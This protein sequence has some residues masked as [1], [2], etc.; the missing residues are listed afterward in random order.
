LHPTHQNINTKSPQLPSSDKT[1]FTHQHAQEESHAAISSPEAFQ[2]GLNNTSQK[3]NPQHSFSNIP[4]HSNTGLIQTKLTVNTPGDEYEQEADAVADKIMRMADNNSVETKSTP[5]NII[6]RKCETCGK[7]EPEEENE[8]EENDHEAVQRMIMRKC[9]A[10]EEEEKEKILQRKESGN[11]SPPVSSFVTQTLQSSG[12]PLDKATRS[13]MERR[14]GYDFSTVRIHDNSLAH[15]SAKDIN[16]LAYTHQNNIAFGNGQYQ[17]QTIQGRRLLAHELTHV[18]QQQQLS[19]LPFIQRKDHKTK[20]VAKPKAEP[21]QHDLAMPWKNS[22]QNTI[23]EFIR[24]YAI[25]GPNHLQDAEAYDL[26]GSFINNISNANDLEINYKEGGDD[27]HKDKLDVSGLEQMMNQYAVDTF[28]IHDSYTDSFLDMFGYTWESF[29]AARTKPKGKDEASLEDIMEILDDARSGPNFPSIKERRE[30]IMDGAPMDQKALVERFLND[31]KPITGEDNSDKSLPPYVVTG[32][33]MDKIREL[34][35]P[36]NEEQLKSFLA[37]IKQSNV[38]GSKKMLPAE[39]TLSEL[40]ET[41]LATQQMRSDNAKYGLKNGTAETG[42]KKVANRPVHGKIIAANNPAIEWQSLHFS[43]QVYDKVDAF[44]VPMVHIH[45]NAISKK[46]QESVDDEYTHYIDVR[47]DGL[48][49]DKVFE[50]KPLPAGEYIIHAQVDHNFYYPAVFSEP[51]TV[52]KPGEALNALRADS[53]KTEKFSDVGNFSSYNYSMGIINDISSNDEGDRAY[54]TMDQK[55]SFGIDRQITKLEKEIA[56][57]ESLKKHYGADDKYNKWVD[58]KISRLRDTISTLTT[59][60]QNPINKEIQVQGFYV[61]RTPGVSSGAL[62]LSAWYNH[63]NK[64]EGMAKHFYFGN[65]FDRSDIVDTENL[66]FE[67]I[68]FS[69]EAMLETLFVELSSEYPVGNIEVTFQLYDNDD[70]AT[71]RTVTYRRITDTVWKDIKAVAYSLPVQILTNIVAGILTIFPPTTAIG[72]TLGVVYNGAQVVADIAS[73]VNT[74]RAITAGDIINVALVLVDL[75]PLLG[76]AASEASTGLKLMKITSK[77]G[78][79]AGNVYVLSQSIYD[80]IQSMRDGL[81][82]QMAEVYNNITILQDQHAPADIL[83]PQLDELRRLESDINE[84][85]IKI[86]AETLITQAAVMGITHAA[87]SKFKDALEKMP[88][89]DRLAAGITDESMQALFHQQEGRVVSELLP[90]HSST[91]KLAPHPNLSEHADLVKGTEGI[92]SSGQKNSE[93]KVRYEI[94]DDGVIEKIFIEAGLDA[95]LNLLKQH[96]PTIKLLQ[97]YQNFSGKIRILLRRMY[98]L[99]MG[100]TGKHADLVPLPGS[101]AFE[102]KLEIEKLPII[103]ESKAALLADLPLDDVNGRSKLESDIAFLESE[104]AR[105]NRTLDLLEMET[106]EGFV[107]ATVPKNEAAIAA[108]YP[109]PPPGHYYYEKGGK[110]E[111]ERF[112]NSNERPQ[113]IVMENGKPAVE[114]LPMGAREKVL[115]PP[116]ETKTEKTAADPGE[117][118]TAVPDEQKGP[119]AQKPSLPV[120]SADPNATPDKAVQP[121][122]TAEPV[123]DK[124]KVKPT[125]KPKPEKPL[126]KDQ[127]QARATLKR[128]QDLVETLY[129]R[130]QIFLEE[131]AERRKQENKTAEDIAEIRSLER[132]LYRLDPNWNNDAPKTNKDIGQIKEAE[133]ALGFAEVDAAKSF[134]TLYDRLRD[135]CPSAATRERTLKGKKVDQVGRLKTKPG[136]L[137]PEHI[138]SVKTVSDMIEELDTD[139]KLTWEEQKA[140]VD[141]P[142]NMIAMD[143]YANSSKGTRRWAN[144]EQAINFYDQTTIDKWI[145]DEIR[146]KGLIKA[147]ILAK[148]AEKTPVTQ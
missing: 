127:K 56:D 133:V 92:F 73:K 132:E 146:I 26:V 52:V 113:Q 23:Y 118:D 109:P 112:S 50:V 2:I 38:K 10:C 101:R 94:S 58:A 74:G 145:G 129:E 53:D 64:E 22:L 142:E 57:L 108:G 87:T 102:A 5:V 130:K 99:Y 140:I 139:K 100:L 27:K 54:G 28:T 143:E 111:L 21:E 131:L 16:A 122:A 3:N 77:I 32:Y 20:T 83:Q 137:R 79:I 103:I 49:N 44:K 147:A 124:D 107:A 123:K 4:V 86:A 65:V 39:M 72:I 33:D 48:L 62:K 148:I 89:N 84:A 7:E 121:V 9:A 81:V 82:S 13:F 119:D 88:R 135:A 68:G 63:S 42:E 51:V 67:E 17:P 66:H 141:T 11:N 125:R 71:N 95:D 116:P 115:D 76:A 46:T 6:Q 8:E 114:P 144:W 136:A 36:G 30:I 41:V 19:S 59:N 85:G 61:S 45:W 97:R 96:L 110:Y 34:Y 47:D 128:Q 138:V 12:Q 75:V 35:Q 126:T 1:S 40:V 106:G 134:K 90:G 80:Q 60:K 15:Q 105:H 37:F 93:M 14:F 69:Y 31:I 70:V 55:A 29:K 24:A 78:G 25:F 91:E 98:N 43:F 104:V 117:K 18:L 120:A